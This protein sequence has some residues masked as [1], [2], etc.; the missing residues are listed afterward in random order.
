MS[1]DVVG[2]IITTDPL[3]VLSG[4]QNGHAEGRTLVGYGVEVVED[5]FFHLLVHLF[6]LTQDHAPLPLYLR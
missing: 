2:Q 5:D 6:H 3:D 4:A 1:V